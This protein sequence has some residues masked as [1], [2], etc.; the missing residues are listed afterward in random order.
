[1][2]VHVHNR[3]SLRSALVDSPL[4]RDSDVVEKAETHGPGAGR[5][6][7]GRA[8][9]DES[10][11]LTRY[12]ADQVGKR[13]AVVVLH[14]SRGVVLKPRAYQRYADALNAIGID[15]YLARYFTASR[16]PGFR[17]QNEYTTTA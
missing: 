7:A 1:M 4:G 16:P 6:M 12:A 11:A 8:N 2:D 15:A 5:V 10:V 3:D 17:S 9:D 14:G 13:P